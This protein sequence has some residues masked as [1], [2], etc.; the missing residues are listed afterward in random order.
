MIYMLLGFFFNF[1]DG[2]D[3]LRM[4]LLNN[5]KEENYFLYFMQ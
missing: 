2:S 3:I 1:H 5:N 4:K